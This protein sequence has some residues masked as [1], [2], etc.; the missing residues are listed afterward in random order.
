MKKIIILTTVLFCFIN[1]TGGCGGVKTRESI[2]DTTP[3]V[4]Q[5]RSTRKDSV[6]FISIDTLRADYLGCY[7]ND[8]I[9]TP[10]IDKLA[11][12]GLLY[13]NSYTPVPVTL[14]SHTTM[15]TGQY[16][17][18]HG[19]RNN[20][21]FRVRKDSYTLAEMFKSMGYETGAFIGAFVLDSRFGLDQGFDVYDDKMDTAA[22]NMSFVYNER[23]AETVINSALD[24][25]REK[26]EN[27]FF[28]WIHCFDPHAPYDPPPPFNQSASAKND[29]KNQREI[30]RKSYAGEIAYVDHCLGKLF[31]EMKDMGIYDSTLIC[32]TADHGE[33]LYQHGEPSHAI[34]I[35]DTTLHVPLIFHYPAKI[36]AGSIVH[37]N[38]S[39]VDIFPTI[40]D[41]LDIG[42]KNDDLQGYSILPDGMDEDE[43]DLAEG[44]YRLKE[45]QP[46]HCETF[47][48]LYNHKWSPLEGVRTREWKYIKAP[49]SE[50]YNLVSDPNELMNLYEEKPEQ[51]KRMQALLEKMHDKFSHIDGDEGNKMIM[52][53]DTRARLESLGYINTAPSSSHDI[54]AQYP[55]PKDMVGTLQYLNVGTYYYTNGYYDQAI[56]QFKKI[57]EINNNDVFAHFVL[58]FV[59][60]K[61]GWLDLAEKELLDTIR[62]DPTYINAYNNLG[63]VYNKMGRRQEAIE[64][65]NIAVSLNP[66]YVEAYENLGVI[67]Y[68]LRDYDN[69][70][71]NYK[72]ALEID[73]LYRDAYNNIGSVYI[74]RALYAEAVN[75]ILKSIE[76][77]PGYVDA[78]NN[79]GSA[80]MGLTKYKDA[81]E[82]FEQVLSMDPN[83]PEAM[84]NLATLYIQTEDYDKAYEKIS[85]VLTIKPDMAK[86]YDCLGT[87]DIKQNNFQK[88]IEHFKKASELNHDSA[89][90][91]YNL[92]IAYFR[93]GDMKNAISAYKKAIS[94]N[95]NN[96]GAHVNLGIVYYHQGMVDLAIEQYRRALQLDNNYVEAHINLGVA[97]YNYHMYDEAID[98]YKE[99]LARMSRN[100]QAYVNLGL[101]YFAKGMYD[102]ALDNYSRALAIDSINRDALINRG[103]ANFHLGKY[104]LAIVDYQKL[105]E[106]Y[107]EDPILNYGLGYCYFQMGDMI[108]ARHYLKEA[109]RL[110]PDYNEAQMLL[111]QILL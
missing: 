97:Y 111:N 102:H 95:N 63:T 9:K 59:Y 15:M 76:I 3:K 86:A 13:A 87:I 75:Y 58:G 16:P 42:L 53:K 73:P 12:E 26:K 91:Y 61:K 5:K 20:G 82:T 34:F 38:V 47:Y 83:I 66:E 55:D 51:V 46:M 72:K 109:I 104:D 2:K 28:L 35:Y 99:A 81:Q 70:L 78:Y 54:T 60:D 39:L 22:E 10:H 50:L 92:G 57:L 68:L 98:E 77:D 7:G 6:L 33:S 31:Q 62:I 18:G 8:E 56:G 74:A 4:V 67:Y 19:T 100:V 93:L 106:I 89:E 110:K 79:L 36:A 17:I 101:A 23:R 71:E 43:G 88:A 25:L 107:P 94:L 105:I 85:R 32:F 52:D 80:Y 96:P 44:I 64:Q 48:P 41:V 49:K 40:I 84:V 30:S 69:A 108:S 65:F 11:Q 14:P 1:I 45:E 24:W 29:V 103:V 37:K 27:P 90:T 21:T